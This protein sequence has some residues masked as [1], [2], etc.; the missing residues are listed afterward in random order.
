MTP[1]RCLIFKATLLAA[2]TLS[3]G[4]PSLLAQG[5]ATD[6]IE[7]VLVVGNRRIPEA[8]VLYY[9]QTQPNSPYNERQ[10][11][12]DYRSLIGTDFFEDVSVKTRQGETGVIITFEV[13]ERPLVRS[14]EYD[15]MKSFK[16]S[17]VLERFRDMRVGLTVDSPYDPAKLPKARRAIR[18][19]MEMNGKPLGRVDVAAEPITSNSVKLIFQIDEGPK[20]RIGDIHFEGNSVLKTGELRTALELTKERGPISLFKGQDKY[21]KDKLEYD[22]QVNMMAKYRERGYLYAR[23]GEPQIEIVEGPRGILIGFRKTKQQYYITIPI[24]EGEQFRY[25]SFQVTGVEN[26]PVEAIESSYQVEE[27]EILNYTELKDANEQLKKLYASRGYLDMDAQPVITPNVAENTVDV[28]IDVTEGRQYIVNRIDFAGNTK[29]RDKVLRREFFLE[30]QTTFDQNRLDLS[31]LRLNQLGFFERIEETDHEVIKKPRDSEVDVLVNVKERS[32]QS[33]GVTGGVS[34][35]SGSFFGINYS[36][37]NF[38]GLGQ[39]IDVQLLA[40]TRTSNYNFRFTDPY[41]RDTKVSFG[42]SVFSQRF[43]FDTFQAFFGQI[44]P[45]DNVQLYTQVSTGVELSGGYQVGRWGRMGVSYT[46][47]TI[48]IED[49]NDVI[50][51]LALQQLV[52]FTPGG[53]IEDARKGIIRSEVRPSYSFN[54]KNSAFQ[55]T[56]G[57][58]LTVQVP[59]AG[60]P[61]GGSFNVIRP[62]VEY[63]RFAPD[64]LISGGRNSF[65]FRAQFQHVFPFGNL[66]SGAPQSVPFFERIFLGGEFYMRGFDIRSISPLAITRGSQVDESGNPVIDSSTGLPRITESLIPVGGDTSIVLT[67]EYRIPIAGPLTMAGFMDFGTSTILNKS[68]LQLFGPETFVDLLDATNNVWRASTGVEIQFLL[69]VVNQPFR[70]IFAYNPLGLNQD[71]VVQ[72]RRFTLEEERTNIRFTVGYTF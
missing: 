62:Y 43:R 64:N 20:V 19:L 8:T 13:R 54:T 22:V 68:N 59:I 32:Q 69:P 72:G 61:L 65:A 16:E 38:R 26:F 50:A 67:G 28:S 34:G 66:P 45:Q 11:L 17:D 57:E 12:R 39:R 10:I 6:R 2:V 15:G 7:Q 27:G 33:I 35:I 71:V 60:G 14:I 53:D 47:S 51:D 1:V 24:E 9:I 46:L 48:R 29:T 49:I 41:F 21:I 58:S 40:G 36:T 31:V 18:L 42:L 55:A 5:G 3:C 4:F 56:Q 30:E 44:A 25:K 63:Q 70:L 23:A 37:N 52:G